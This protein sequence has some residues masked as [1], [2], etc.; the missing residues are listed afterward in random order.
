MKNLYHGSNKKNLK[1]LKPHKSTHGSYVYA[2]PYKELA[3]I[4]SG[5]CGDDFTFS[6]FRNNKYEPW[7]L[8]ERIPEGFNTMFNNSSS[9]YT[10]DDTTFYD[11][12]TGFSELVSKVEVEVKEE[13]YLSNVYDK[14][15]ELAK[16]NQIK[17]YNYPNK[18]ESI[19]SDNSDL[20]EKQIMYQQKIKKDVTKKCFERLLLL[21]P[22]LLDKINKKLIE[23]NP[24]SETFKKEDLIILFEK[25]I[26]N[27]NNNTNE[28]YLKSIFISVSN[29]Y[30]ELIL[31]FKEKLSVYNKKEV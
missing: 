21:H 1:V 29:T 12:H 19:P 18:P 20:I 10:V 9:I 13:E 5:R 27:Q 3:I 14:V 2:T 4:F 31:S 17:L 11:I 8:V 26:I 25:A 16:N 7:N 28:Q 22:E 23:I 15:K 30:P 6:L 24:K